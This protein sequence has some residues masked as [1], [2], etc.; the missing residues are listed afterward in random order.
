MKRRDFVKYAGGGIAALIVGSVMPSWIKNPLLAT[1]TK[2]VQELNFTITDALKDMITHNSL[3]KAQCYFWI[4][5]E[6]NFPEEVPGPHIYTSVG[7]T[8]RVNITNSLDENHSFYISGLAD[9][10]PIRPG[11][12]KT[13]EFNPS[14]AGTYLYYDN[15]NA[16]V[17]RMMGLHGAFI[18]MP[19]E[20]V[21]G[22]RYTPY[23]NPTPAVQQL[24]DDFG[25]TEH[26]PGLAWEEEDRSTNTHP[27]RQYVWILHEASSR[28]FAEVGKYTPGKDYP[29]AQFVKAFQ[30]DRFRSDGLN[31]KPEFFTINGQS[32]FF[33][34]HNLYITPHHRVGEPVVIRILNA[35]L[36][37]H[38][39]HI[40]ANH[41]YLTGLNGVVQRNPFWLDTYTF[42]PMDIAEWAVPF[43]RPPDVPNIRGIGLPDEPLMSIPNPHMP[44]SQ[45]HPVWPPLDEL[46]MHFPSLG[47]KAGDVEI[48]VRQSP[49]CY[50]MHDHSE[51]SQSAQ[52]GNYGMG[53]MSGLH[54]IGDRNTPGGVTTFPGATF[55][56]EHGI[57][58][59]AA[60]PEGHEMSEG[61]TVSQ[62][63][64]QS[65]STETS[66]TT[67]LMN[68]SKERT[69]GMRLHGSHGKNPDKRK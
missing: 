22:H 17:N 12:T 56:H 41:V 47:T 10:G 25:S 19:N 36:S 48:S 42:H 61:S 24:F 43:T 54:F 29:A 62:S 5:K 53:M 49:I 31:R 9:S 39:L 16:P 46:D 38:S 11:E 3:N 60:G 50:P 28:L 15:L 55:L 64:A 35:G 67:T 68:K 45:P 58:V 14:K 30:A 52:G 13:L 65:Q 8:V 40:H 59:M 6:K 26:F 69:P 34:A 2:Q 51:P 33:A 32:G 57:T 18:V 21:S 1:T 20:A 23:S 63:D 44:G 4:Y 27:F 37:L 7:S 66:T